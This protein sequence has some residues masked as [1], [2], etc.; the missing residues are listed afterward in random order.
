M[1]LS[2]KAIESVS[3]I[4]KKKLNDISDE[5]KR[6][7][8]DYLVDKVFVFTNTKGSLEINVIFRFNPDIGDSDATG[9]KPSSAH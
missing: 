4:F 2:E 6:Q 5:Q 7:I 3:K 8:V 1:E 9:V